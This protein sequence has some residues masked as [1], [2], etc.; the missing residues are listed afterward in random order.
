MTLDQMPATNAL[1]NG[2]S[3]LLILLGYAMVRNK[4]VS[5]HRAC[6][7][8]ALVLSALFLVSYLYYHAHVGSVRYTG[9]GIKRTAYFSILISH[10]ILAAAIVPLVLRTVYLAARLRLDEHRAWAKWTF[11]AWLYV[12]ITGVVIYEMLY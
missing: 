11:P 3:A 5:L 4:N 7:I 8:G 2:G 12:S 10:S 6:M 9:V 1:L